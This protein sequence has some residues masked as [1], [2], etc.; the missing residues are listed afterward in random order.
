MK[1]TFSALSRIID[2]WLPQHAAARSPLLLERDAPAQLK[3]LWAAVG[4][5]PALASHPL[6]EV[7][8]LREEGRQRMLEICAEWFRYPESRAAWQV[9]PDAGELPALLPA[10]FRVIGTGAYAIEITDESQD[11][12]DP[13]VVEIGE[14][15]PQP[16]LLHPSSVRYTITLLLLAA[17]GRRIVR[18]MPPTFDGPRPLTP[19]FPELQQVAGGIWMVEGFKYGDVSQPGFLRFETYDGYCEHVFNEPDDRFVAYACPRSHTFDV[20]GMSLDM[21]GLRKVKTGK[22]KGLRALGKVG[23]AWIWAWQGGAGTGYVGVGVDPRYR[24]VATAWI[25]R[26]HGHITQQLSPAGGRPPKG[27]YDWDYAQP[28]HPI[29]PALVEPRAKLPPPRPAKLRPPPRARRL[30]P[31]EEAIRTEA[32]ALRGLLEKNEPKWLASWH[33]VQLGPTEPASVK[34]FWE[35]L[36]WSEAIADDVA[37]PER[38]TGRARVKELM[39]D[40]RAFSDR[41]RLKAKDL[42]K[43]YRFV[44][45]DEQGVGF[46]ITDESGSAPDP[47][48]ICVLAEDGRIDPERESYVRFAAAV[49]LLFAL[50]TFRATPLRG[51]V[52]KARQPFPTLI[53]DARQINADHWLVPDPV[54]EQLLNLVRK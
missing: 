24:D 23:E 5:S 50:R 49:A 42:P 47:P 37:A 40:C 36:G 38:A 13:P 1:D 25:K 34:V 22:G 32:E 12:D 20:T 6:F 17:A 27:A 2:G 43:H 35:T 52:P 9:G 11:V 39:A 54:G 16:T 44:S 31:A 48:V 30:S 46:S 41:F 21:P 15:R 19:L 33:A 26:Q 4:R 51:K 3:A 18:Q 14:R 10:R 45:A 53:P 28:E 29:K 7:P 8:P